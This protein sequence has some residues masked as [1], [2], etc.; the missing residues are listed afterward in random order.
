MEGS[1]EC[2]SGKCVVE[3]T[4]FFLYN[5]T[6]SNGQTFDR[7]KSW[8]D[9]RIVTFKRNT[10]PIT[11]GLEAQPQD[12]V[13]CSSRSEAA[14]PSAMFNDQCDSWF[15]IDGRKLSGKPNAKGIYIHNGK[16]VVN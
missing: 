15:T 11:T 3:T 6:I 2:T 13:Q 4:Q 16:A 8:I 5:G 9:S 10:P 1:I 7:N 12:N 14:E